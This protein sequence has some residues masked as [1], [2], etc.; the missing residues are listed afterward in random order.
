MSCL[1]V[2][3]LVACRILIYSTIISNIVVVTCKVLDYRGTLVN[4]HYIL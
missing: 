4:G 3:D 1:V 2:G